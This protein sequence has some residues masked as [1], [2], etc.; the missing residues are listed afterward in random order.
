[1]RSLLRN[2][3]V[4]ESINPVAVG[5]TG[6]GKTGNAVDRAGY[7]S[8]VLAFSYGAITATGAAFTA[9]VLH[10]DSATAASFTSVADADLVG[11]EASVGVAAGVRTDGVGDNITKRI[12]YIGNKRYVKG[13]ITSTVTAATPVSCQ[14]ILG[15]P[16]NA[17]VAAP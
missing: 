7:Q 9:T 3:D 13:K 17:P 11:T 10:S 14:V 2:I 16:N 8:V 15:D 12:G 1:M 4:V 6:T 5:T